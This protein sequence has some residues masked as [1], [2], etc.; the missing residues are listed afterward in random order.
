MAS[1]AQIASAKALAAKVQ[2]ATTTAM[3]SN[4]IVSIIISGPL[5]QL[6]GSIRQL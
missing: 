1:I 6:L 4:M 3:L 5:Q 2:S